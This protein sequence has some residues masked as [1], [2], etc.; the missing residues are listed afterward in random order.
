M[1]SGFTFVELLVVVSILAVLAGLLL[2]MVAIARRGAETTNT[3]A[4]LAKVHAALGA[5]AAEVG[6]HPWQAHAA[7]YPEPNRLAHHLARDLDAA[8]RADLQ[9]DLEMAAGRYNP[10]SSFG[11]QVLG[12]GNIDPRSALM[13]M[14]FRQAHADRVNVIAAQ[15]ARTAVLCGRS[16]LTGF[17]AFAHN[18]SGPYDFS[19]T[20]LVPAPRSRGWGADYLAGDIAS[21][22]IAG[23]AIVDRWG[24]PLVY[25][26]TYLP[27]GQVLHVQEPLGFQVRVNETAWIAESPPNALGHEASVPLDPGV[28]GLA[29]TPRQPT[30]N[31]ASDIRGTAGAAFTVLPELWSS[32]RDRAAAA[33]RD[34]AANRDNISA[35]PYLRGLR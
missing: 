34:D 19:G 27:G 33:Q 12:H 6:A 16:D 23:D 20:R 3:R 11:S 30:T 2:P 29:G 31:L 8:G 4:L 10:A 15:R 14:S 5:F 28:Y 25:V 21:R 22:E 9:A 7:A 35:A 1:R 18:G 13:R 24:R 32:G 17:K 26:G